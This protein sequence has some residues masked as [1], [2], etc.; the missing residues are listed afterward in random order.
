ME[1][2]SEIKSQPVYNRKA[3]VVSSTIKIQ[4]KL[5]EPNTVYIVKLIKK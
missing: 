4:S 5:M 2:T 3:K 1:I